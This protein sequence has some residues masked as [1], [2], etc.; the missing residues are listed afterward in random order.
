MVL[1]LMMAVA[2]GGCYADPAAPLIPLPE[3]PATVLPSEAPRQTADGFPNIL[4]DPGAVPGMPRDPDG[5][6][7]Q[8]TAVAGRGAASQARTAQINRTSFAGALQS[9]ATRDRE[10]VRARIAASSQGVAATVPP[11]DPEEVRRRIASG[12]S[13]PAPEQPGAS[14]A[15]QAATGQSDPGQPIDPNAPAPR[16]VGPEPYPGATVA[17]AQ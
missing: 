1:A 12:S 13:R 17:P 4:A 11:S 3:Q 10:A 2:L 5:V 9:K 14:A 8:K 6:D 16:A 15:P 7:A